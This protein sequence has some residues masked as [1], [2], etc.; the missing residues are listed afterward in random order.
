MPMRMSAAVEDRPELMDN[1]EMPAADAERDTEDARN[2]VG[3][4]PAEASKPKD[5]K[6][7]KD[8]TEDEEEPKPS[9]LKRIWTKIDLNLGT[10]KM[11]F[12]G[13]LAPIIAVAWYESLDIVKIFTTLGYLVPVIA[14]LSIT[15]MP[16]AKYIQTLILNTIGICIGSAVALL[17]I[18]S[19]I[20]ARV[21]T[22][23][24]GSTT[25]YNSSQAAV[26]AI[27]LFADIYLVNAL[28]AKIPAL[29][30]PAILHS[31]FTN[32]AF[33]FAPNFQTMEQAEDLIRQLL[34]AFL[35]AFAISTGVSLFI[36]PVS[37]RAVVQKGQAAYVQAVRG[38]LKAHTA[39]IQSL[40]SSDMFAATG[41]ATDPKRDD[42]N[43]R[44]NE[45]KSKSSPAETIQAK[46]LKGAIG[47]LTGL[48]G[49][50]YGD[51]AFA[52][53]EYAWG[54]LDAKDLD[55]IFTL[56]RGILIPLVG[57][58]TITDIF[59]RT[60]ERRGWVEPP[61]NSFNRAES[62][63][64]LDEAAISEEKK[65]WNEVMK[66]LHEPFAI[67]TAAM[68]GGIEHAS[69][70]LEILPK[71]K[72]KKEAD[73][74]ENGTD[75][76][77]GDLEFASFLNQ[78]VVDFH[79]KRG[80]TLKAWAREK[81][82]SKD[83]FD[84]AQSAPSNSDNFTP[85]EAQHRRDQQQLYLMLYMEHL[86]Y[87]TGIA[88]LNFVKFADKKVED[89]TMKKNRLIVPGRRRIKK[90]IMGLGR[91]DATVDA[92]YPDS[93]EAGMNNVYLGSGFNKRKDPEHLPPQTAWQHFGNA[94]R[95]IPRF[96]GSPESAFGFRVACATLTIGIVAFLKD[97]QLFF[98][99]QRLVWAMI[100]IAIGMNMTSGEAIFGFLGRML[101]TFI[102]AISS[103]V[104]WY[105]VGEKTPGVLVFLWLFIF[106]EMYFFLKFP[107]FLTIWLV[108]IVTQ[109]MVIAYELQVKKIGIK[110]ASASGQPY[111]PTY[112]LAF[113]RLACVAGGSFVAFIWT[114]FP[115]QVSDRSC[116]RKELGS[117]L[118]LLANYYS[119]VNSTTR[120]RLH[121]TEEDMRSKTSPHRQLQKARHKIFSKLMMILPSLKKHADW[122]KWEP[123]VGGKFPRE[124]YEAIILRSTNILNYLS[125]ISYATQIWSKEEGSVPTQTETATQRAWLNDLSVLIEDVGPASHQ[126]TSALSLLSASITQGSTLPPYI[127]LPEPYYL[128][129]R[130]EALDA[131]I[132]GMRH[133]EEP[134]YSAY[135]CLQVATS[136]ITDD[137]ARLVK[138]V[139][140][141]VG[142]TDFSFTVSVSDVNSTAL[143]ENSSKGKKD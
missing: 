123:T 82:L 49:K 98:I 23:P 41:T 26:C 84:N 19:A 73:V 114:I 89:G 128:N 75:P 69:L 132:L 42:R 45:D 141:L 12:K 2:G 43:K 139:K 64:H 105:I 87:F 88:V 20:Q 68:D 90:W 6:A 17:G 102:A 115:Y 122:Q 121:N 63:E 79:D 67:A 74:E 125:I 118:Y 62:W 44:K 37:S 95:T 10:L 28:R 38:V 76:R 13:S 107:R 130:L 18:W 143:K 53:R 31:I 142:E 116:L 3:D 46:D 120:S 70:V 91:E 57:M 127:Q 15:I 77:P 65:V 96:L 59:E 100:I 83:Q 135:A 35:S 66:A 124:T 9:K 4:N 101:G 97:T 126:I 131:G 137:L 140:D 108:I 54:K 50:L 138:H 113:Y 81:G 30:F 133:I 104:I 56:F 134:G 51:M 106:L 85:D 24:P 7:E 16:R 11:M 72:K 14:V 110:A 78:K 21:H 86:L 94:L 111:Y 36:I 40:G 119:V 60:A 34:V 58:S 32:V 112:Q 99:K 129:K 47:A 39:Y 80:E 93:T 29:Q 136:L 117:M 55:E 48:H 8:G 22:T 5:A 25:G 1:R 109:V 33:T 61:E 103:L 27:W 52:K 71:P 92:E